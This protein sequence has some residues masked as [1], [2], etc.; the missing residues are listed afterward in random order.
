[1]LELVGARRRDDDFVEN[2]YSLKQ[3]ERQSTLDLYLYNS[4]ADQSELASHQ[5]KCLLGKLKVVYDQDEPVDQ[6]TS[7]YQVTTLAKA[8]QPS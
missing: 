8:W 3:R 6:F 4:I 1:M 7:G 5:V 2:A